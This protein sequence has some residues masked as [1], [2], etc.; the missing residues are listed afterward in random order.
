MK[1]L[2]DREMKR[3]IKLMTDDNELCDIYNNDS[4][5]TEK[6]IL[7]GLERE[8]KMIEEMIGTSKVEYLESLMIATDGDLFYDED[9]DDYQFS[10]S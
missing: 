9:Y 3:R 7:R 5:G 8:C 1:E 6:K 4:I 10:I 2:I